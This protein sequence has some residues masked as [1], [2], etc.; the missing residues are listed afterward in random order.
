MRW[1]WF[2]KKKKTFLSAALDEPAQSCH[3]DSHAVSY[4]LSHWPS[5]LALSLAP[6]WFCQL[7]SE[8]IL[9]VR[10]PQT[11]VSGFC[12]RV[13]SS[14][15]SATRR[16]KPPMSRLTSAGSTGCVTWLQLRSV[17]WVANADTYVLLLIRRFGCVKLIVFAVSQMD[18]RRLF[19]NLIYWF[20]TLKKTA[21]S[22]TYLRS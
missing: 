13:F 22:V 21:L 18:D 9:C 14:L 2:G 10:A 8:K 3:S 7:H 1:I 4:N 20:D 15:P 11:D 17:W 6:H 5:S 12:L 16:R 19:K